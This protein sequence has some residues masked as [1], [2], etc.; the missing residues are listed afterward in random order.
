MTVTLTKTAVTLYDVETRSIW[1]TM[2]VRDGERDVATC[3]DIGDTVQEYDTTDRAGQPLRVVLQIDAPRR[4]CKPD[5]GGVYVFPQHAALPSAGR[6]DVPDSGSRDYGTHHTAVY[7]D[8]RITDLDT[9]ARYTGE[10]STDNGATWVPVPMPEG[11]ATVCGGHT[12]VEVA[13]A[14]LSGWDVTADGST[15]TIREWDGALTRWT[16]TVLT[17]EEAAAMEEMIRESRARAT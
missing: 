17:P 1:R 5:Q 16:L 11:W 8:S 15:R 10:S 12:Q 6:R 2:S 9:A 14:L 4:G 3:Y 13:G 7:N